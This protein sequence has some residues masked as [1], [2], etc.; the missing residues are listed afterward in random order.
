MR[1]MISAS[2]PAIGGRDGLDTGIPPGWHFSLQCQGALRALLCRNAIGRSTACQHRAPLK[3][4]CLPPSGL[5]GK[6]LVLVL[7]AKSGNQPQQR[8]A[9]LLWVSL[10]LAAKNPLATAQLS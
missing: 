4:R 8:N 10:N 6:A 1:A 7:S 3:E 9:Q 2:R 5:L